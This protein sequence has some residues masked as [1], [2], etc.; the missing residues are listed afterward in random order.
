MISRPSLDQ[1]R[2]PEHGAEWGGGVVLRA[3]SR[4]VGVPVPVRNPRG[5]IPQRLLTGQ[6]E[7]K[8]QNGSLFLTPSAASEGQP[9][10]V[11]AEY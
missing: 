10:Y 6:A 5:P 7:S 3:I 2:M 9:F 4:G 11:V 1:D 8:S